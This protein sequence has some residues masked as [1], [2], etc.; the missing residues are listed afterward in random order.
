MLWDLRPRSVRNNDT[1]DNNLANLP[2]DDSDE[3]PDGMES[4]ADVPIADT[5][6]DLI[7]DDCG[8]SKNICRVDKTFL[9]G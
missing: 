1:M 3:D 9:L 6:D 5:F 2:N 4:A 7:V 8:D